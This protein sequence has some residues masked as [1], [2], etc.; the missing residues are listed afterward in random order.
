MFN[1]TDNSDPFCELL[2]TEY[3]DVTVPIYKAQALKHDV[4]H[5]I[6]TRGPPISAKP[7][8]LSPEKLKIAR[9]E[10]QHML[11]LDIIRPSSSQWSSPLHM[12]PQKTEGDWRPC[13]DYR[14]LNRATVPDRYPV[15]HIQDFAA[16]LHGMQVF[17]KV[18]LVRAYHQIPVAPDD[19]RKTAICT[20]F[21]LFEFVRM[22][23]GLRNAAQSFQRFIDEVIRGLPNVYAY[24]DD[25]LVASSSREEHEFHLRQLFDRLR[26][27]GVVVNLN[28]CLFGQTE[29]DFLGHRINDAGVSPLPDKVAAIRQ[30]SIPTSLKGLRAFLGVVNFYRRFIPDC[31]QILTPLTDLLRSHPKRS[32]KPLDW[33]PV[34]DAAFVEVKDKLAEITLLAYPNAKFP[35]SLMVDASDRAIGGVVQ[36]LNN[37]MATA[38]IFL[39]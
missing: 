7:R 39:A 16:S 35:L 32:R 22:P 13:G 18:D 5:Y 24:I 4:V 17:S 25:L 3:N 33:T 21:G 27:F 29:L 2:R 23:F 15:P 26:K 12:V 11:D 38:S 8:R 36:Q 14:A 10:F 9:D 20:P 28:K 19:V 34:C 30:C 31:A 6:D 1:T 37:D